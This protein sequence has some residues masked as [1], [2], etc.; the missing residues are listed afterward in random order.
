MLID[1]G[2]DCTYLPLEWLELLGHSNKNI[3]NSY[4]GGIG[5]R[6]KIFSHTSVL[7]FLNDESEIVWATGKIPIHFCE[8]LHNFKHGLIGRD[9][10]CNMWEHYTQDTKN[11]DSEKWRFFFVPKELYYQ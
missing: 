5:A 6:N 11:I 2:A 7:K 8:G 10:I 3:K 9:I 1:T 4:M